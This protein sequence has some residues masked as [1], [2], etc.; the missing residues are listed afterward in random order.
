[1]RWA[2][3][4]VKEL[5]VYLKCFLSETCYG[6]CTYTCTVLGVTH[7]F[8]FFQQHFHGQLTFDFRLPPPKLYVQPL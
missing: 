6:Q 1:M 3:F 7:H 2:L 8:P 4:R 5:P